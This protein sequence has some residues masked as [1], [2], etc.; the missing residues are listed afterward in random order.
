MATKNAG[1]HARAAPDPEFQLNRYS[2]VLPIRIFM[3]SG[4]VGLSRQS[5]S[6]GL[7]TPESTRP[8]E[9]FVDLASSVR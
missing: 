9:P 1:G 4:S 8:D 6:A 3:E 7:T 5:D 2:L